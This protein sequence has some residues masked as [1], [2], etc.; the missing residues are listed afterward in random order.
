MSNLETEEPILPPVLL[1]LVG[2]VNFSLGAFD[3]GMFT[4]TQ[5]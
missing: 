3:K 5:N 2:G 1:G 4:A